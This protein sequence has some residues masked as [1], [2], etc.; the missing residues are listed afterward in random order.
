MP[1]SLI[2]LFSIASGLSV[3][4]V[5]YAQPLLDALA[6]DFG[7]SP[8]AIGGVVTATQIGCALALLL[9]VPLGDKVD[10][11]YLMALQLI[12]LVAL[13]SVSM[14][15]TSSVL[16]AGMLATGMLGT[17]MTQGLIAYAA[18]AASPHEQ[19]RVV[20]AAQSGV[21]IGLLLA[22]VFAGG[23]SDIAGWRGVYL[24]AAV[25]MLAIAFPLWWRLPALPPH[26]TR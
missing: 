15:Q 24:A 8:A 5:Y 14:A 16:L 21:F 11:R 18:S 9:L 23:I 4:N 3:A 10:R 20:G 26:R 13:I 2:W 22:R 19:G 1:R 25:L 7:I 6:Q 17:A 12:A